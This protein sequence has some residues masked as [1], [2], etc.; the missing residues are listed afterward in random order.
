MKINN[1]NNPIALL[2]KIILL[3]RIGL[4]WSWSLLLACQSDY[5]HGGTCGKREM[6]SVG[7]L[8]KYPNS[9]LRE[10]RRKPRNFEQVDRQERPRI[11]LGTSHL[12]VL[13]AEFLGHL[14][15]LIRTGA[16]RSR[17]RV[18]VVDKLDVKC[19]DISLFNIFFK[20]H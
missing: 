8:L 18:V 14:W 9:C 2:T 4:D 10:F 17:E 1:Y 19:G 6:F 11:E 3:R 15:G 7:I 13:R 16:P 12:P 5:Q 20:E